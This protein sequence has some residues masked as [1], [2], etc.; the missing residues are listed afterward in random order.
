[1]NVG[2]V[3]GFEFQWGPLFSIES[4]YVVCYVASCSDLVTFYFRRR[5]TSRRLHDATL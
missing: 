3:V 2:E 4:I 1:M 5:T